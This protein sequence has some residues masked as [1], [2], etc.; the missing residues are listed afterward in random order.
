MRTALVIARKDLRQ[1]VRDRSAIVIGLVAPL[2]IAA[3]MSLAFK[4][5]ESFHFTLGLV[6]ADHGPVANG[7]IRALHDPGLRQIITVTPIDSRA[8]AAAAVRHRKVAAA[9]VIP[10][11]LSASVSGAHPLP[12]TAVTSVDDTVS[13]SITASIASSLVAQLNADR[14]SVAT[15]L[16]AGAPPTEV[17]HLAALAGRL[18]IPEQAVQRPVG[19]HQLKTVSY[20]SPGMAI[21]FL[22]FTVS[23]TSRS[24]FV[25]R[26][27]GM[28]ERMRAAPV[29]PI[30]ILAGKALSVFVYGI[31]S[32][33]TIA[34][35]TSAAFGADWGSPLA[36]GILGLALVIA[37]VCVTAL[38]IGISRT[39]RQAEG[40]SSI[41]VFGLALLG[42]NFIFISAAPPIMR[43][44]A[45]L[46]PN[47]WAM[48]GFTDLATIGG[49]LGTVAM[50]VAAILVFSAVVGTAAV[51]LAPRAVTA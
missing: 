32:L 46:T 13:G 31:L 20:Y 14:L 34:V 15:A 33:G 6:D 21:F 47:G 19:A 27:Q 30:E 49:G 24:F 3:I 29:R 37:V 26:T 38:V 41:V 39:P 35:I 44:L 42:G 4:G 18:R 7:L 2:G 43:H 1:R 51:V 9:L 28:I 17:A 45:L 8:A 23:F 11:G 40:I 16:A 22:L 10:A 36:A 12:L 50:P 25:D 48:R 5:T